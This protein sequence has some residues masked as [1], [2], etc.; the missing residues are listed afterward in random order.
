M[1]RE[2]ERWKITNNFRRKSCT[3]D[4]LGQQIHSF[5]GKKQKGKGGKSCNKRK[6]GKVFRKGDFGFFFQY[7]GLQNP[8][9]ESKM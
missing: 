5:K 7:F 8:N 1:N 2:S 3:I 6:Y 9:I 4:K